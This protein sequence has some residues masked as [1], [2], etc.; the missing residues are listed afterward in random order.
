MQR[1]N[2][3]RVVRSGTFQGG[4]LLA[5]FVDQIWGSRGK[6][7]GG[8]GRMR[9]C[10]FGPNDGNVRERAFRPSWLVS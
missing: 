6:G 3:F 8:E 7:G 2:S 4:L 5:L 9:A 10:F 1:L